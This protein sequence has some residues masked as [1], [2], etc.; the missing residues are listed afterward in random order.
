MADIY[1]KS[2][3]IKMFPSSFRG[4]GLEETITETWAFDARLTSEEN[5]TRLVD[6]FRDAFV[7]DYDL[8]TTNDKWIIFSIKGYYFRVTLE[9]STVTTLADFISSTANPDALYLG[10]KILLKPQDVTISD[11]G[12]GTVYNSMSLSSLSSDSSTALDSSISGSYEFVGLQLVPLDS[13][14]RL[15]S[16][17][18]DNDGKIY[19]T[20]LLL[21]RAS[22]TANWTVPAKCL[23]KVKASEVGTG[24][25]A[26]IS[27]SDALTTITTAL[28]PL[29]SNYLNKT[30]AEF[31]TAINGG[32]LK[33]GQ[34]YVI[35]DIIVDTANPVLTA[36]GTATIS[37]I[38]RTIGTNKT[39]QISYIATSN[40]YPLLTS[41]NFTDITI[42]LAD[43][44]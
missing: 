23:I 26:E 22:T 29:L 41:S 16:T 35:S 18:P 32:T 44:T 21:Q 3:G 7:V 8:T 38:G 17:T 33:A 36:D 4:A 5:M 40:V 1:V 30:A 2:A 13:A 43:I 14:T 37:K 10:A 15:T 19:Y 6:R 9:S 28:S 31:Q 42:I 11:T 27:L 34:Q 20:F 12:S 39:Y 24:T 25:S